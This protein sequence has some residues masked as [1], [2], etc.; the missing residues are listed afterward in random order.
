[1]AILS[2]E[3]KW[4]QSKVVSDASSNGGRISTTEIPYGSSNTF[5]SNYTEAQL[6]TG[7]DQWRK[8]FLRINSANDSSAYNCKVGLK[9]PTSGSD[10]VYLAHGTQTDTQADTGSLALYGAGQLNAS[11]VAGASSITVLLENPGITI[12]R[13]GDKIRINNQVLSVSA[14]L[15]TVV[16]GTAE[17]KTIDSVNVVGSVATITITTPLLYDYSSTNSYVSSLIEIGTLIGSVTGKVVTSTAGTFT[18]ANVAVSSIGSIYQT[19]TFTFTSATAFTVASDEITL[20]TT[21]G[22]INST[23]AP[24]NIA[25]GASYISVPPS[26]W[27][28]TYIAGNTVKI[29]TVPP[30]AGIWERRKL[31]SG[32]SSYASQILSVLTLVD[33]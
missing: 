33:S 25:A 16:S 32:L 14:G 18:E 8:A 11:V 21:S 3:I 2:T 13:N 5:W 15:T 1:M 28:G 24:T 4:Y 30:C 19:L 10:A 6:A 26:A 23:Y 17:I 9:N 20:P 31:P 22:T 7:A 12:F 27:G 29:T